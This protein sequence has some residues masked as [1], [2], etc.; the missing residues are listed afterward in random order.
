MNAF[1]PDVVQH[2]MNPLLRN[3]INEAV[4]ILLYSSRHGDRVRVNTMS[5]HE[6]LVDPLYS[7]SFKTAHERS[8][9][10]VLMLAMQAIS[11]LI[12]LQEIPLDTWVMLY[13]LKNFL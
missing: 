1:P 9:D 4:K 6:E 2:G 3:T 5:S 8:Q 11:Y 7:K 10:S 12:R 13:Y